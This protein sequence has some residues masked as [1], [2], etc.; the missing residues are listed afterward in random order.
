L[1]ARG[2]VEHVLEIEF[3]DGSLLGSGDGSADTL[4][5]FAHDGVDNKIHATGDPYAVLEWEEVL[6]KAGGVDPR[7]VTSQLTS[8]TVTG[9]ERA[10]F[11]RVVVVVF[12]ECEEVIGDKGLAEFGREEVAK[13]EGV[14]VAQEV[15]AGEGRIAGRGAV[16][17]ADE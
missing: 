2:R 3:E 15:E 4:G 5:D 8:F 17:N 10:K 12:V 11:L 16:G 6:G 7:E 14:K 13:D 1:L 9:S